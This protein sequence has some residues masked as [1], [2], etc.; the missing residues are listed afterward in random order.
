M[1]EVPNISARALLFPG[2]VVL[3]QH[4]RLAPALARVESAAS[5]QWSEQGSGRRKPEFRV[6]SFASPVP[7]I[8]ESL[9]IRYLA[10]LILLEAIGT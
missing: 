2:P 5:V 3:A 6:R 9:Q 10:E 4:L 7:I 8:S 1:V